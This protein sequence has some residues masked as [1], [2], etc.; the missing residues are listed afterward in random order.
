MVLREVLEAK[1]GKSFGTIQAVLEVCRLITLR[2]ID[3]L[4]A[5][6]IV[7]EM[8]DLRRLKTAPEF[9]S[10]IGH[11]SSEYSSGTKIRRGSITKTGNA[12][13]RRVLVEAARHYPPRPR[14]GD[15]IRQRRAKQSARCIAIAEKADQRLCLKGKQSTMA[16]VAVAREPAGFVWAMQQAA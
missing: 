6:T 15:Q 12:H 5:M 11:V 10:A 1:G 9:M 14:I 3:T 7:S 4:T 13:V 8:R 2:G 16:V